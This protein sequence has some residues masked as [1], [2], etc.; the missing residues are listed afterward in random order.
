MPAAPLEAR[1]RLV[2]PRW[3]IVLLA[4]PPLFL[5]IWLAGWTGRNVDGSPLPPARYDFLWAFVL[6]APF[7]AAWLASSW[8]YGFAIARWLMRWGQRT[9]APRDAAPLELALGIAA[10]LIINV[11]AGSL[12][13]LQLGG[14]AGAWALLLI[15]LALVVARSAL[16]RPDVADERSPW[17]AFAALA[18]APALAVLFLAACSAP[19]WLWRSEFGGYDAL[20]YHLQLP[21]EWLIA[22]RLQGFEHNVYSFMPSSMEAAYYHL[23]SLMGDAVQAAYA[24]QLLHAGIT[25]TAAWLIARVA[26]RLAGQLA[27]AVAFVITLGTPWTIITGSLAYNDMAVVLLFAG[28]ML[29]IASDDLAPAQR[30]II[31]GMLAGAAC[32]AKLSSIGFVA[33]PIAV[34]ALLSLPRRAMIL[35]ALVGAAAFIL[36]LAPWLVRNFLETGNPCFPFAA[37]IF[38]NGHFSPEQIAIW[39]AGHHADA[40][41]IDRLAALW[42]EFA[43]YG[44]GPAPSP[45]EPWAPQWSILPW[46]GILGLAIACTLRS[47]RPH[48]LR[49]AIVFALQL[50]FWL[51]FTHLKSRFLLPTIVPLALGIAL[52]AAAVRSAFTAEMGRKART[53]LNFAG[54]V[55]GVIWCTQPLLIFAREPWPSEPAPAAR[56]GRIDLVTGEAFSPTERAELA[57][58]SHVIALRELPASAHTLLIGEAAPFYLTGNITYQTTWDRGPMSR[59]MRDHP[60]NPSAWRE[61][62]NAQGF[63]HLFVNA[64]MLARWE[65]AGWNDPLITADR[66][67]NFADQFATRVQVTPN[68]ILYELN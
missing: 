54:V 10:M 43:R 12:G 68:G 9:Q 60:D 62:L 46:L 44:L 4:L 3:L 18:A 15:G 26:L 37:S 48:A 49:L 67:L 61:S 35:S 52:G 2:Q 64:P 20:S 36:A 27:A 30:A 51:F 13:L 1:P 7:A 8:G 24:C 34:F 53:A 21:R 6:S 63:T 29:A 41:F 17:H 25:L 56:V 19:A 47:T 45:D 28:A 59:I 65:R 14:S 16:V 5:A 38:G 40:P 23:A 57:A 22:G 39:N 33:V 55:A 58:L 66:I 31:S 11:T 50:A 42:N 32:G